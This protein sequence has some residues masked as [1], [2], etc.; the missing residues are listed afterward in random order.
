MDGDFNDKEYRIKILLHR[1]SFQDGVL[2]L[3]KKWGIP[4]E[5]FKDNKSTHAWQDKLTETDMANLEKEL[6]AL[7]RELGLAERWYQGVF[8][9]LK[10]NNPHMLRVQSPNPIKLEYEGDARN[11]K[12]VRSVWVQVDDETTEE[13]VLDAY[14]YA[15]GLFDVSKK[16]KQKPKELDRNLRVLEMHRSGMST[17]EITR[18]LN[19]NSDRTYNT[20]HVDKII[21]RIKHTLK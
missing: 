10:T 19:D 5:G 17:A 2:V 12:N 18:W 21:R 16:K 14:K 1:Q 13:E 15:K 4:A 6:W 7:L 20:D 11:R 9:Y 8:L 3:R